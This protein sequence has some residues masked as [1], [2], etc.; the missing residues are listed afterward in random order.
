MADEVGRLTEGRL[1]A[2]EEPCLSLQVSAP[3]AH[4]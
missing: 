2:L 3:P 1:L 4:R